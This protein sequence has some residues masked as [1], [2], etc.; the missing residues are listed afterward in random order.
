MLNYLFIESVMNTRT[1]K[2]TAVDTIVSTA[3]LLFSY[4]KPLHINNFKNKALHSWHIPPA[5]QRFF[6]LLSS[7]VCE[8]LYNHR[9]T[10]HN[11]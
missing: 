8:T 5:L 1:R 4:L 10:I 11:R 2:D 7:A 9:Y 3:V 6:I